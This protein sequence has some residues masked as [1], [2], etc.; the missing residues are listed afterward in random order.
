V[1]R[2]SQMIDVLSRIIHDPQST[3]LNPR[4]SIHDP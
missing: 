3:I 2:G 4:S 1:D